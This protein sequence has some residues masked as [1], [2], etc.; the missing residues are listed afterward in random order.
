MKAFGIFLLLNL[1]IYNR[2]PGRMIAYDCLLA[3]FGI[4]SILAS[5]IPGVFYS[6]DTYKDLVR[7]LLESDKL[8]KR[9]LRNMHEFLN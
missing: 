7:E 3:Y 4:Y 5:N 6:W 1:R 8:R 2:P 9:G